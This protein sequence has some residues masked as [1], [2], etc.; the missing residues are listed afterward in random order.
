MRSL[1]WFRSDLRADDNTALVAAMKQ[2]TVAVFVVSPDEWAGHDVAAARVELMLRSLRELRGSLEAI[3]V[4]LL[5]R[6]A[7]RAHEVP[8]LIVET[9]SRLGCTEI[10]WNREYEIDEARRDRETSSL[11]T[12]HGMVSHA[13]H[14]QTAIPPDT[15]RT[16]EGRFYSVFTPFR[17]AWLRAWSESPSPL[18]CILRAQPPIAG[19]VSDPIPDVVR[20]HESTVTAGLWPGGE[21]EAAARLKRFAE[22]AIGEYHARRDFPASAATSTLSPYLSVGAI[23]PR[24]CMESSCRAAGIGLDELGPRTF[25]AMPPGP[26]TWISELIWREFYIHVLVGFPR[27]CMGRAFQPLADRIRWNE[28]DQHFDAWRR[29]V[30]GVPIVD[31]GMRQLSATGWMH[32][33]VRMVT[34]MFL[35]KNLFL[36]WR[37]GERHFMRS[38]V[39]GCF[40]SNN[41]GWQW[42]ASTGTDA[43]PYFR[44]FN[45]VSQSRANDARGDYI[46]QW[47]PELAH[48]SDSDIHDPRESLPPLAF[49]RLGYPRPLVDLVVSRARAI[50]AFRLMKPA[51][52]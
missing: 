40:A 18:R 24:R 28:N 52:T 1:V 20:G 32:N 30:T 27:V 38:L 10:H 21:R 47:V 11:C 25:D 42:S 4:P 44:I 29:G 39:D 9:A 23:S 51:S 46:R 26:R 48:L 37:L 2:P 33:R 49:E 13:H 41:G 34:A 45:P 8:G 6:T 43:A 3:N 35:S 19:V 36:D 22:V 17:K 15:L 14:D 50:E 5:I 31:A 16:G 7:T 12:A